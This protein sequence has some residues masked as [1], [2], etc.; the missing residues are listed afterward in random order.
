MATDARLRISLSA[1][2]FEV[3]GPE[4]FVSGYEE[5]ARQILTRLYESDPAAFMSQSRT[6][7]GTAD[8]GQPSSA[9][10][11]GAGPE[12]GEVIHK[13]PRNA[14]GTDQIL[15]AGHYA[16]M[17]HADQAFLTADASK[18]LVGQGIKLT[19]PAQSMSNNLKAKRVFKSG[20]GYKISR[21]GTERINQLLG[22]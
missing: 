15:V 9:N 10:G 5:V 19:N 14:T 21:E 17:A 2:E 6:D 3:E 22:R 1:G 7:Q 12:F 16:S 11:D 8:Q 18:L 4:A 20:K 13:L